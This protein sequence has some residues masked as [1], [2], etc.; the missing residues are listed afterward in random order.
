MPEDQCPH[1]ALT[2]LRAAGHALHEAEIGALPG[3]RVA[4]DHADGVGGWAHVWREVDEPRGHAAGEQDVAGQVTVH[5]LGGDRHRP[6]G[7]EQL[8]ERFIGEA[9]LGGD[10][11]LAPGDPIGYRPGVFATDGR[12]SCE[13]IGHLCECGVEGVP[14]LDDLRPAPGLVRPADE[15]T[16][17]PAVHDDAA[18]ARPAHPLDANLVRPN[19]GEDERFP[20]VP[21]GPVA[22]GLEDEIARTPCPA[23]AAGHEHGRLFRAKC[24]QH[25]CRG[26][27]RSAHRSA[28]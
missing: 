2:H 20:L 7:A 9:G 1:Q 10:V 6:A 27:G 26:R 8:S 14:G 15:V 4:D 12:W 24:A 3:D 13:P 25:R 11:A 21:A 23:H 18:I 22:G 5:E 28:G 16:R 19:C 17:D